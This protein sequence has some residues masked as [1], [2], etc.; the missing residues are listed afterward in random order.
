MAQVS[1]NR[2]TTRGAMKT[3]DAVALLKQDHREVEDLFEEFEAAEGEEGEAIAQ[4][5]CALLTIHAQIEEE[6][7]YPAALEA[8]SED[9]EES[10]LV[11]E[12]EVEHASAKDLIAKIEAMDSD[13]DCYE[14]TVTVLSE[15][16]KHHVKEEEGEL[17]PALKKSE[18]DLKELGQQLMQRKQELMDEMGIE[19][20]V[21]APKKKT[22]R[23]KAKRSKH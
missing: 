19:A 6:L 20:A 23:K 12:A 2:S 9:E 3:P 16:I 15:Y 21:E 14:A 5:I 11:R 18:L 4:R 17:F 22:S 13:D 8:L 10:E 1:A 7:V